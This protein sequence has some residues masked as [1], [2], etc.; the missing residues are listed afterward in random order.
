MTGGTS[1]V[2]ITLGVALCYLAFNTALFACYGAQTGIR[3]SRAVAYGLTFVGNYLLF[4]AF[5]TLKFHLCANWLIIAALLV[6]EVRLLYHCRPLLCLF[7]GLSGALLGL[8]VNVTSRSAFA[9]ALSLPLGSF[10]SRHPDMAKAWAIGVG[11]LLG[12]C[13]L[14][15]VLP[16][17]R[18]RQFRYLNR[19]GRNLAFTLGLIAATFAYLELNL[20][21]YSIPANDLFLKIWGIKTGLCAVFGYAIGV[22]YAVRESGLEYFERKNGGMRRGLVSALKREKILAGLAWKDDLTGCHSRPYGK[23]A[24]ESIMERR[25]PFALCFVDLNGLKPV[26]D[27]LGHPQGDRYITAVA[28]VLGDALTR[29]DDVLC[30]FGGDEFLLI[31]P[32]RGEEEAERLMQDAADIVRALSWSPAYPF[33]LSISW[34]CVPGDAF[35]DAHA[36]LEEADRRMYARKPPRHRAEETER[37][38]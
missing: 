26:N 23:R 1:F 22:W 5:S 4:M 8:A 35:P 11:F 36:L 30:R 9:I 29:P 21:I 20:L 10:D 13:L 3:P 18:R 14:G 7:L 33:D 24:L 2:L 27:G 19:S 38:I 32:G 15:A 6:L 16:L 28:Q 31:L 34:G 37:R 12:A 17:L 25:D